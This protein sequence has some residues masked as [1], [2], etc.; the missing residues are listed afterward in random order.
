MFTDEQ[1]VCVLKKGADPRNFIDFPL[2]DKSQCYRKTYWFC[3]DHWLKNGLPGS[4]YYELFAFIQRNK[5]IRFNKKDFWKMDGYICY[6]DICEN[7]AEML[8]TC[9]DRWTSEVWFEYL[10]EETMPVLCRDETCYRKLMKY[11]TPMQKK[12]L[13]RL[14]VPTFRENTI[15]STLRKF[16]DYLRG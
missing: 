16:N 3:R 9:L 12:I 1:V 11:L 8:K 14:L 2:L 5:L 15:F 13:A 4:Q 10:D 6:L 7:K